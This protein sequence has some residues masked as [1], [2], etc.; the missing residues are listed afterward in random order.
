[1][2]PHDLADA[3]RLGLRLYGELIED[4]ADTAAL[5]SLMDVVVSVDSA[6]AH[7]AGA[8]AKPVWVLLYFAAEWRWLMERED[9]PWYPTARLFRQ[10]IALDWEEVARRVGDALATRAH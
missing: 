9:S 6:P 8:M 5:I 3:A 4:F 1:M 7:L 2:R 10:K